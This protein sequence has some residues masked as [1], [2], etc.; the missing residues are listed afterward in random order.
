MVSVL[1]D[2]S[3]AYVINSGNAATGVEGSV[4]VVNLASGTVSAT[5]PAVSAPALTT[6]PSTSPTYVYGHPNSVS[7]TT[8]SPTGKVYVTSPDSR[9]LTVI[10][11]DTDTVDT[12]IN[13]QGAGVRVR[14]NLP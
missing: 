13:I 1:G 4:S 8:G 2:G 14:V 3:R 10:E 12:H 9:Y 11:T 5:I 7:A 6:D